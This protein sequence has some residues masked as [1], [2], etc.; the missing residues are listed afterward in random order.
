MFRAGTLTALACL[1]FAGIANAEGDA[2]L[3]GYEGGYEMLLKN[4]PVYW[5]DDVK[6]WQRS[7]VVT[8]ANIGICRIELLGSSS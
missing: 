6:E 5:P 3:A 8:A 7:S 1:L 4:D 2:E